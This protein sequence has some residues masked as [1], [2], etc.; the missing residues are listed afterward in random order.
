[1]CACYGCNVWYQCNLELLVNFVLMEVEML[2]YLYCVVFLSLFNGMN[3]QFV[4]VGK[5]SIGIW[6]EIM[7]EFR[8]G[9]MFFEG[10]RVVPDTRKGLIRIARVW[11]A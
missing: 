11:S 7:L 9:K 2:M 8:A 1:M 3:D 6:Q 4:F 5:M 10:K